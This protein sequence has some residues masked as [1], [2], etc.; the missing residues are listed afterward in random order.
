MADGAGSSSKGRRGAPKRA[1]KQL[2]L[3]VQIAEG[4]Q[5]PAAAPGSVYYVRSDSTAAAS[6][7]KLEEC[8]AALLLPLALAAPD[9]VASC[10][11]LVIPAS[12]Q[13]PAGVPELQAGLRLPAGLTIAERQE[14]SGSDS[15]VDDKTLVARHTAA[16]F[17]VKLPFG[18][19]VGLGSVNMAFV[20]FFPHVLPGRQPNHLL[21]AITPCALPAA[22]CD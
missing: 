18:V 4:T 14:G 9:Q 2:N 5:Q 16:T 7:G 1:Y 17:T 10:S 15:S 21:A 6:T 3:L 22:A 19:Q 20:Q 8:A 12:A 11:V 13:P